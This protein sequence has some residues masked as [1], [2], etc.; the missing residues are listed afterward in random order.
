M[1]TE[2]L[3]ISCKR[4]YRNVTVGDD[5][6][7]MNFVEIG[8]ICAALYLNIALIQHAVG[9]Y[10]A[11]RNKLCDLL[12]NSALHMRRT[13]GKRQRRFGIR[14]GRTSLW[15]EN[16]KNDV[17]VTEEW[18]ENF[19][20]SKL[21][22]AKLCDELKPHLT[23]TE[24]NM[25]KP[26]DVETQVAVTLYYLADEGRY[27]KV[28]NAFGIS[29]STVSCIVRCVTK[30]ISTKL[31][32]KYIKLPSTVQEVEELVS[33]Y[34]KCHGFP[35]CIGAIDGTH[36]NI[37]QPNENYTDYINR[38]G[39]YSINVQALCDYK[40]CFTDVVVKWPGSVHDARIFAN[41]NLNRSLRDNII[42]SCPK[43]IVEGEA[44]VPICILG[45]PAYPLLPYV[46]K[47]FPAGGSTVS[48]Q[49]FGYRMS[50][51]RMT[52]ECAFGRLKGRFGA[53]RRPMDIKLSDLPTVIH[54]CFVLHNICEL[55]REQVPDGLVQAANALERNVQPPCASNRSTTG[56]NETVGRRNRNIFV[57]YF[58]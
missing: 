29:S 51:A 10:A 39:K 3:P 2:H 8:C 28:A 27:R 41:S 30:T 32:L 26:L 25:R 42:P 54:S 11:R 19:R 55:N 44:A 7:T 4:S 37:Q 21:T 34:K 31:G 50:S 45:D 9:L 58:D 6:L 33:G 22:F 46:M 36:I 53:L 14:P 23:K 18:Q 1:K 57:K 48:E 20:M 38:K 43:V 52:I 5:I 24:T 17:V 40:Y 13:K 12:G 15:W 56:N 35:Q 16:F 47:E 49:F